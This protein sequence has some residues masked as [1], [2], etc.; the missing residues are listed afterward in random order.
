MGE[1][2]V[3]ATN[4]FKAFA[5]GNGA[6][7]TSQADYNALP[8]L[9]S[10]FTSGKASSAQI[11]KTIRQASTMASLI[12]QFINSA[13]LDALDNGNLTALLANYNAALTKNLSL[14]TASKKDIGASAGQIP[15]MSYFEMFQ[16]GAIGSNA[17]Y[18]KLPSGLIIQWVSATSA[19]SNG[20]TA[21][22]MSFPNGTLFASL[23]DSVTS[24]SA[25]F[26]GVSWNI[27]TTTKNSIGW[28]GNAA[29][30]AFCIL[31]IGY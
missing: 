26:V 1:I 6:N 15:D 24:T 16:S 22:P 19:S 21:L 18:Q 11:N 10:G 31:A 23:T 12:G 8:A 29:P 17:G 30:G 28:V 9:T 25:S 14:G 4:D 13:G 3:M 27:S 2:S 5:T 7:V 20:T